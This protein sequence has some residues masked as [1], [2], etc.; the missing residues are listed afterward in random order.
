[1]PLATQGAVTR[2]RPKVHLL[3]QVHHHTVDL[4]PDAALWLYDS[5]P[6]PPPAL[7]TPQA[8]L[9]DQVYSGPCTPSSADFPFSFLFST[10][11]CGCF[12]YV[13]DRPPV[14]M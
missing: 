13:F 10:L 1:M 7:P 11:F 14:H 4:D 12:S 6:P 8:L 3:L 5:P 9:K 2:A